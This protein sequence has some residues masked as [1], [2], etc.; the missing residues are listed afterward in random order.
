[1]TWTDEQQT[2]L[3]PDDDDFTRAMAFVSGLADGNT[4]AIDLSTYEAAQAGRLPQHSIAL[5]ELLVRHLD[6]RDNEEALQQWRIG[7]AQHKARAERAEQEHDD[8]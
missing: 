3:T 8:E 7:L 2:W 4:D 6:L 5:G 1:M